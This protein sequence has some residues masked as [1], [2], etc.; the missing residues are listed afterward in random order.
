MIQQH[1]GSGNH[2]ICVFVQIAFLPLM[3]DKNRFNLL[4]RAAQMQRYDIDD[5][6]A[7]TRQRPKAF[8]SLDAKLFGG[9]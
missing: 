8:V 2:N 6:T 7:V 5:V 4:I 1:F 3:R 9:Y